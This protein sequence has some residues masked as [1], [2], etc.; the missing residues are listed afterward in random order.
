MR[1]QLCASNMGVTRLDSQ[2]MRIIL[3]A[4]QSMDW[5]VGEH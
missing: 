3:V 1:R 5:T 4:E 2:V